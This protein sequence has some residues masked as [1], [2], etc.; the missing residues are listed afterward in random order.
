MTTGKWL[1]NE[2]P[3]QRGRFGLD[4]ISRSVIFICLH[5]IRKR[6][7]SVADQ[8]LAV[9]SYGMKTYSWAFEEAYSY[10]KFLATQSGLDISSILDSSGWFGLQASNFYCV[11]L[12]P[13]IKLLLGCRNATKG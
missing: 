6:V 13:L 8:V 11:I 2:Q 7:Y 3:V 5:S 10:S 1:E 9:E 4:Q 12:Q